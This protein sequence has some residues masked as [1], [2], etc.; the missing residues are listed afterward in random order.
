MQ[1][2]V[3]GILLQTQD[4]CSGILLCF[5]IYWLDAEAYHASKR[6]LLLRVE[7]SLQDIS[8]PF[9]CPYS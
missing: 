1:K 4:F 3:C 9:S 5:F 8:Y 2:A 6:L 7:A